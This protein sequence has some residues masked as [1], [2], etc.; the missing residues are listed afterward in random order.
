VIWEPL[1]ENR[2]QQVPELTRMG[3]QIEVR[4]RD[5]LVSGPAALHANAVTV[6]DI[7]SGAALVIAALVA[8]GE[9]E[10]RGAWHIDRGYQDLGGKL[11]QLGATV[12]RSGADGT[13]SEPQ[14]PLRTRE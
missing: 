14:P 4:G 12:I 9:T 6:P 1:F 11:S 10:L 13:R 2:F 5:V 7:R 3:A 8:R